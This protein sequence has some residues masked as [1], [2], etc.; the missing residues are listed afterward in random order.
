MAESIVKY[1][2]EQDITCHAGAAITGA[3]CVSISAVPTEGNPTVTHSGAAAKV[4]GISATDAASGAKVAVHHS[5]G[6]VYPVEVGSGGVTAGQVVEAAATGVIIT[7]SAGIPVGTVLETAAAG[8]Q[9][10]VHF[11]PAAI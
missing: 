10:F 2:P 3:R 7:R 4:F 8:A 1:L 5:P 9:A 11:T 6:G